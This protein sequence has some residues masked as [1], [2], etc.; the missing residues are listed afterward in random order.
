MLSLDR[1][2]AGGQA[3][4]RLQFSQGQLNTFLR[5]VSYVFLD[6]DVVINRKSPEGE[7]V[8]CWNGFD[9]LSGVETAIATLNRSGRRVLSFPTNAELLSTFTRAHR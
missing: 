5:H 2:A 7:Y 1:R 3:L 9:I 8:D 4:C 6:R